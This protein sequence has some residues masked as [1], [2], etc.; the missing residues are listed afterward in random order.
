MQHS[1]TQI[2]RRN[3][4]QWAAGT[5]LAPNDGYW[6]AIDPRGGIPKVAEVYTS[7]TTIVLQ[8]KYIR[9][10]AVQLGR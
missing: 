3:L 2:Q 1:E 5:S 6:V 9:E 8:Q 4:L 10:G 7:G